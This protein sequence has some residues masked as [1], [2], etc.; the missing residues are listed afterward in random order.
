MSWSVARVGRAGVLAIRLKEDFAKITCTE[1]E[2]SIKN[3]VAAAILAAL[4]AYPENY[5]VKVSA[6]GSQYSP[7]Q[8]Q[9]VNNLSVSIDPMHT[10]EE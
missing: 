3:Q 7:K 10:F 6:N 8:G 5:A 4:N 1:P 2:E 9:I